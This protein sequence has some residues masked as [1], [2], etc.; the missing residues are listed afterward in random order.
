MRL[1]EPANQ[2][3]DQDVPRP[4]WDFNPFLDRF[5]DR[6]IGRRRRADRA[7]LQYQLWDHMDAI[8]AIG[9]TD[10]VQRVLAPAGRTEGETQIINPVET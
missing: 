9:V 2:T 10:L 5:R 4:S 1:S 7:L 6:L 8:L 3:I